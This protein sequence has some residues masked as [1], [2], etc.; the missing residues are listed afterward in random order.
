MNIKSQ[1]DKII[2]GG[3]SVANAQAKLCQDIDIE[4]TD[5][6]GTTL[7]SKIDLGVHNR[8]HKSIISEYVTT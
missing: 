2:E 8:I 3:Y 1:V 5:E 7:N 4:I 6:A